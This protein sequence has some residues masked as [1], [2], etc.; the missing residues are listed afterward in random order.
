M[1]SLSFSIAFNTK[2]P[3]TTTTRR[4]RRR[5]SCPRA[6]FCASRRSSKFFS[7]KQ[8]SSSS[9]L[10]RRRRQRGRCDFFVFGTNGSRNR[11]LCVVEATTPSNEEENGGSANMSARELKRALEEMVRRCL[12]SN[13]SVCVCVCAFRSNRI[14]ENTATRTTT[15]AARCRKTQCR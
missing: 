8:S 2:P 14:L 10:G 5:A 15:P 7:L 13:L 1:S 6:G 9:T 3:K 12:V 11:H 4:R